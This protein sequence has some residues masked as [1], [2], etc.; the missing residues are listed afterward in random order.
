M[1][2]RRVEDAPVRAQVP[3][4]REVRSRLVST[5][6][7]HTRRTKSGKRVPVRKHSRKTLQPKRAWKNAK[8]AG[9]AAKRKRKAAA[10]L[11]GAAAVS[12]IV[13]FATVRSG[14]LAL[15]GLGLVLAGAG[16]WMKART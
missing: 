5:V 8:R 15:M 13:G 12:E 9:R 11:Y 3:L 16:A 4:L 10:A 1:S 2:V 14:G 6:G 7:R